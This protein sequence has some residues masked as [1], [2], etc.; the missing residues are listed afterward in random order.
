MKTTVTLLPAPTAPQP[1]GYVPKAYADRVTAV[2]AKA[3]L[4][5]EAAGSGW[6]IIVSWACAQPIKDI[7]KETDK[8]ID[9]CALL[10]PV[11]AD[12]PWISMGEPG[13]GVDGILWRADRAQVWHMQAEG[14]GTMKRNAA[15]KEWKVGGQWANG[16]W[17]VTFELPEW[18][19]LGQHKQLALAIWQG[20]SQERAGLKSVSPG[21][22]SIA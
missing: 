1:G 5:V 15:P 16:R 3:D 18:A 22:I 21:W 7:S 17:T 4:S 10:A 14:L 2:T 9:A 6:K 12:A 11:T 20:S 13:K 19:L 8:F